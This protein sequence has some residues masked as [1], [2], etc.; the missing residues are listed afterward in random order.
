[1]AC[2]Q[3]SEPVDQPPAMEN[4]EGIT[5]I[6]GVE[7]SELALLMREMYDQM[8]MIKDSIA[9]GES[10]STDFYEAFKRIR[11]AHATEPAKIDDNYQSMA[12]AFLENYKRFE[13]STE[14]QAEAYNIM[15]QNCVVCHEQKCPGPVKTINKLKVKEN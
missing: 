7:R 13:E 1:M 14:S 5:I 2:S 4:E 3:Q 15:I 12:D 11:D 6:N 8:D 10:I 9:R